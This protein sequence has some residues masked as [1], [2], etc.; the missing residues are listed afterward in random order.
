MT[1]SCDTT[2]TNSIELQPSADSKAA[3]RHTCATRSD[4][5]PD[6]PSVSASYAKLVR[7]AAPTGRA[8]AG[9]RPQRRRGPLDGSNNEFHLNQHISPTDIVRPGTQCTGWSAGKQAGV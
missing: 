6:R 7:P 3:T 9:T 8:P 5:T 1:A 2:D 4:T